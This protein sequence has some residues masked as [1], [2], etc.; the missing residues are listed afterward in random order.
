MKTPENPRVSSQRKESAESR[1]TDP[2]FQLQL[3][4]KEQSNE[5]FGLRLRACRRE[6]KLIRQFAGGNLGKS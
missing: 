2:R 5:S 3:S 4:F 1:F 6:L